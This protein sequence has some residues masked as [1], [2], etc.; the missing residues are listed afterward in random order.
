MLSHI[1]NMEKLQCSVSTIKPID[2]DERWARWLKE[3]HDVKNKIDVITASI[4]A[5]SWFFLIRS[6]SSLVLKLL[7]S[8]K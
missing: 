6:T 1:S 8:D 5:L 2:F 3:V 7:A 4:S